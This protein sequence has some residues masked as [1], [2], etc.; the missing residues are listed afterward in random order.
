MLQETM[1]VTERQRLHEF[2][3]TEAENKMEATRGLGVRGPRA[4]PIEFQLFE[5]TS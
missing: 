3:F 4:V 5:K 1:E 2:K